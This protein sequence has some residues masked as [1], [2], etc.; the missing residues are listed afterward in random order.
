MVEVKVSAFDVK[1]KDRFVVANEV[2][3]RLVEDSTENQ[4]IL[5]VCFGSLSSRAKMVF[6]KRK[7]VSD[8]LQRFEVLRDLVDTVIGIL[9]ECSKLS[10]NIM[11][12]MVS[13][14]F[15]KTHDNKSES[16]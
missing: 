5:R 16:C 10:I 6:R 7:V 14:V 15:A 8:T 9:P 4:F 11:H 12:R 2:D 3:P 1:I 13:R